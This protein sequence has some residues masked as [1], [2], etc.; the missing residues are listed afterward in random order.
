MRW[1]LRLAVFNVIAE[2]EPC[3]GRTPFCVSFATWQNSTGDANSQTGIA[4]SGSFTAAL[5]ASAATGDLH[6]V[7]GGNTL[8]NALGT[9]IPGVT[10]D[11]D[12]DLRSATTLTIGADE[13]VNTNQVPVPGFDQLTAQLL[14]GGTNVL[15]FFGTPNF[16]YVLEMATNLV[17]PIVW[18]PLLTNTTATNGW[19][20]FTNTTSL[21]TVFYRTRSVP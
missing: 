12:G 7:P 5:F 3:Y 13:Y 15:S 10:T 21:S 4:G 1:A 11:F 14:G 6:L 20:I 18:Q 16:N 17:P 19:L 9:P 8:V 2:N